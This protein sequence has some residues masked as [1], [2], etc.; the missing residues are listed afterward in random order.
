MIEVSSL[1]VSSENEDVLDK[2]THVR[3]DLVVMETSRRD[4]GLIKRVDG[5]LIL[6][7]SSISEIKKSV[8]VSGKVYPSA[9]L[10]VAWGQGDDSWRRLTKL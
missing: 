6:S 2:V 10:R 5:N 4:L 8:R 9:A 3:G 7:D 1:V